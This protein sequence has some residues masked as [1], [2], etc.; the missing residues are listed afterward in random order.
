MIVLG[1]LGR[2]FW[3]GKFMWPKGE[4]A[5][6]AV[7]GTESRSGPKFLLDQLVRWYNFLN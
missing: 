5:R 4:G 6:H 7:V 3:V 1:H 2:P